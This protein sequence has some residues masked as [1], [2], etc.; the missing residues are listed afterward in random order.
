MNRFEHTRGLMREAVFEGVFPGAVLLVA[1]RG[2]VALH[3]A[4]GMRQLLPEPVP[5]STDTIYDLASL[6]KAL[7]T[8]L[9]LGVLAA[10][11]R[12]AFDARLADFLPAPPDKA[13]VTVRELASHCSG[14][15][16]WRP[17]FHRLMGV[18]AAERRGMLTSLALEEPLGSPPGTVARYSD[19]GYVLLGAVVERAAG[20]RLDRFAAER[21]Y[22][23]LGLGL[24][25]RPQGEP[26]PQGAVAATEEC[27]LRGRLLAG[28]VHDETCWAVGGVCGHAG[29]FGTAAD[30]AELALHLR[31][32]VR[33]QAD[34]PVPAKVL[35]RLLARRRAP[36]GTTW[37]LGFDHP[38][39]VGSSAGR[40]LS[41]RSVGHLGFTG[42][43]FWLDLEH[44]LLVVLLS[45]RVHPT[46]ANEVIKRFRPRL[47]EAAFKEALR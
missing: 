41:R 11:K 45:N 46:R 24:H 42:C 27:S 14:L 28:E 23:P 4:Y 33:G 40:L 6:T 47:H 19:P 37:G 12:L 30:V 35:Q 7:A 39:R 17:Y 44:D 1:V 13:A 29:L 21:I 3:E 36:R 43:S 5:A 26:S 22:R 31:A 34:G 16:A 15:P 20:E 10:E 38:N 9:S 32:V 25:F 2:E 8:G 18:P